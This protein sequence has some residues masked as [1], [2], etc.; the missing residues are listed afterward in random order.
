MQG[1][2]LPKAGDIA[3]NL[4]EIPTEYITFSLKAKESSES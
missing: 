1:R 3:G 4:R 2:T